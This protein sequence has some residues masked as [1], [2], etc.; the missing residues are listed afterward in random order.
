MGTKDGYSRLEAL[1]DLSPE[2]DGRILCVTRGKDWVANMSFESIDR[3]ADEISEVSYFTQAA[4]WVSK[5][6]DTVG[7][8]IDNWVRRT[9]SSENLL[10]N[11]IY[12]ESFANITNTD[13]NST[14]QVDNSPEDCSTNDVNAST[15]IKNSGRETG[16][17]ERTPDSKSSSK[18]SSP[19]VGSSGTEASSSASGKHITSNAA[20]TAAKPTSSGSK[21]PSPNKKG[22][23]Q[24]SQG[25]K[26]KYHWSQIPHCPG[27]LVFHLQV[28]PS[29]RAPQGFWV[30]NERDQ[31]RRILVGQRIVHDHLPNLYL[32]SLVDIYLNQFYNRHHL[33]PQEIMLMR[34]LKRTRFDY[35]S[36]YEN[37]G[38]I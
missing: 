27:R 10:S 24:S 18:E 6:F 32:A 7:T 22:Q 30:K 34:I 28:R 38:W 11:K 29:H 14:Q 4:V 37:A 20:A 26:S 36:A 35:V 31:Y 13:S 5:S 12:S 9:S 17:D 23:G 33:T 3:L 25:L 1:L 2:T 16:S 21:S 15:L 8:K 19:E